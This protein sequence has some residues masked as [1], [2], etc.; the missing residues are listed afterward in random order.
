MTAYEVIITNDAQKDIDF[1]EKSEAA[2]F[3]K[4]S[5]LTEE[6]S[7]HPRTGTGKPEQMKYGRFKGLWS[8]RITDKHRLVYAIHDK[9]VTV[10]VLAARGHYD[11]K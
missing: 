8:R 11:D 10:Y 4:V 7:E 6:L 2:A 5:A 1:L 3:R 9:I